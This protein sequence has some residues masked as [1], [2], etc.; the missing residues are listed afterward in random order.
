MYLCVY[1]HQGVCEPGPQ[2]KTEVSDLAVG[3]MVAQ[4][5]SQ[6]LGRAC[7]VERGGEWA[8]VHSHSDDGRGRSVGQEVT[9]RH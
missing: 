2:K 7:E 6:L 3:R 8:Q 1:M 5:A 4:V 9:Q